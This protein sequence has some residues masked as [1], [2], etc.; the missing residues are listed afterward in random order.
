VIRLSK[1]GAQFIANFEGFRAHVYRDA[2]GV[3]TIGYGTTRDSHGR[4]L[5]AATSPITRAHALELLMRD[6]HEVANA[7][8]SHVHVPIN[9]C[10]FD[11]LVSLGYNIGVGGLVGSTVVRELNRGHRWRAGAAFL[12]WV[13]GGGRALPGL[14][15]RRRAERRLFRGKTRR[16]CGKRRRAA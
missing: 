13:R 2:V 5:N 8:R 15:N 6:A 7:V 11:A 3:Y 4:R 10:E 1:Q 9:Q 14:V 16:A 12:M